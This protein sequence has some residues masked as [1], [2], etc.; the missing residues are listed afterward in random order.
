MFSYFLV[1]VAA[2][3]ALV[4]NIPYLR[5]VL[6]KEVKPHPYSWFVWSIVSAVTLLG[7]IQKG[8]GFAAVAIAASEVF[9]ILIFI[10]AL[11]NG[12]RESFKNV[13][14]QDTLFLI[15]ALLGLV[16][17]WITKDPTLSVVVV[18]CIDLVAFIPTLIKTYKDP[19]SES[20]ILFVMNVLRH[21]LILCTVSEY[22]IATTFHS[23]AMILTNSL[24]TGFIQFDAIRVFLRRQY[25]SQ[26]D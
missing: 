15:V 3:L 4:G 16:P 12:I 10:F 20:G 25:A 26:K 19:K 8:A 23:I 22:N 17:W 6:R 9:T 14:K 13:P 21:I 1:I 11:R 18:V 5:A 24:M 2:V 7:G